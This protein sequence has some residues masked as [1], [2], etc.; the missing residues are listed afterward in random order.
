MLQPCWSKLGHV[1]YTVHKR[2]RPLTKKNGYDGL[3]KTSRVE[4][5][6]L[7][8]SR[9]VLTMWDDTRPSVRV[10]PTPPF[11][12]LLLISVGARQASTPKKPLTRAHT[13]GERVPPN[14]TTAT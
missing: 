10:P 14:N 11:C 4:V 2:H 13:L 5:A 7:F 9:A 8:V 1:I 6:Y 12:A 3:A